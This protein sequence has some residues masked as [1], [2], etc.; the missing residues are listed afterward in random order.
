MDH[1]ILEKVLELSSE[2]EKQMLGYSHSTADAVNKVLNREYQLAFLLSPI[3]PTVLKVI[4]D[5]GDLM[6]RKSIYFYPKAVAGLVV[7]SLNH[8]SWLT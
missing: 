7:Y 1:I 6:P 8:L 2:Q 5:A 3:R 4:A